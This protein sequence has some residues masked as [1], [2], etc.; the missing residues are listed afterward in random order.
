MAKVGT[1]SRETMP[2][3]SSLVPMGGGQL[4][5]L[6]TGTSPV[7]QDLIVYGVQGGLRPTAEVGATTLLG[8]AAPLS[9]GAESEYAPP[10][11][12]AVLASGHDLQARDHLDKSGKGLRL[13]TRLVANLPHTN[14]AGTR[15]SV[16][17]SR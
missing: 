3:C 17:R 12:V 4:S 10:R 2:A 13:K 8:K 11:R 9:R 16:G 14:G 5:G 15:S 1:V 6:E 7:V